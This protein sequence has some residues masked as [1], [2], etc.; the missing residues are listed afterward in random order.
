MHYAVS[1]GNFDI[2]SLLL[3]SKVCD[4]NLQNK[5]GYTSTMLVSLA[6]TV[7]DTHRQVV[8]RLFHLADVNIKASQVQANELFI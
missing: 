2:V 1:L 5:A 8:R 6:Q 7:Q 3:N 4:V